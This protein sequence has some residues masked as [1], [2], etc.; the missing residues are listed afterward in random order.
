MLL[1]APL[2]S[3]EEPVPRSP[4]QAAL[5][6]KVLS[7]P[8]LELAGRR[9]L[10]CTCPHAALSCPLLR[11]IGSSFPQMPCWDPRFLPSIAASPMATTAASHMR[12]EGKGSQGRW[13]GSQ[14]AP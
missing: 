7:C 11:L 9:G 1:L 8:G 5:A 2:P 14:Q 6:G 12:G 3:L 13:P 10:Q 4:L